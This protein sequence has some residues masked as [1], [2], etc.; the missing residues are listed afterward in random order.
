[1]PEKNGSMDVW[2]SIPEIHIDNYPWDKNGRYKPRAEARMFYTDTHLHLQFK[3][4]EDKIRAEYCNL[5]DMVC[6]DSCVEFFLNPRPEADDRYLNFEINPIGT[7]LL[8]IGK[9]GYER[10]PAVTKEDLE[11]FNIST[12]VTKEMLKDYNDPY[13]EITYQIPFAYLEKHY[14]KMDFRVGK[15]LKANFYKCGN[16]TEVP[17]YGCWSNIVNEIPDFHKPEFFG[18][19][20]LT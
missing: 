12:S 16:R 1:M 4:F 3:A 19:L 10:S 9:D 6:R 5:N 8:Y 14:G 7:L 2:E 11:S 20:V 18:E 15:I 13:W 17:H